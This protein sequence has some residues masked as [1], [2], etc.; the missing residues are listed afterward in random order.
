[1]SDDKETITVE[2]RPETLQLALD[3][4]FE[5][6]RNIAKDANTSDELQAKYAA[7]RDDLGESAHAHD[8]IETADEDMDFDATYGV[9]EVARDADELTADEQAVINEAHAIV[10]EFEQRRE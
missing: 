1:M 8:L 3:S 10:Q 7:A 4:V 2:I 5:E 6:W 9:L